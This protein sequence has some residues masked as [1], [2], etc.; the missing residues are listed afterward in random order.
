MLKRNTYGFFV[1]YAFMLLQILRGK[2]S[3]R[4]LPAYLFYYKNRLIYDFR[5]LMDADF[6]KIVEI[7]DWLL[8]DE[9][10]EIKI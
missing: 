1:F 5:L 8:V 4:F 2:K 9:E 10:L 7:D 6:R 3:I